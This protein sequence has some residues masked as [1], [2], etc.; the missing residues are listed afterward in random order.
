MT[1][2]ELQTELDKIRPLD[3]E[4][5]AKARAYQDSLAKPPGSLGK[6][7]DIAVQ[8]AG[9][10]GKLASDVSKRRIITL[11]ADNGITEEGVSSAPVTVTMAQAVNMTKRLTG[12]SSLAKAF[13]DDVEV[14]DV[15]IATPYDCPAIIDRK[16]RAGTRN[17]AKE[18]ALTE[19]E[20]LEAIGVGLERA[21]KASSDG[22]GVIGVGE[23]GIGNTTTSAAVLSVLTGLSVEA[24]TGRGGGLT[25]KAFKRKKEVIEDAIR[26]YQ[27]DPSDPINVIAKVGGLDIAAMCGVFLGAAVCRIPVVVDGFISVVAALCA[28][29]LAPLC[30]DF[31]FPSHA[32]YE[33]GY[34]AAADA[35]GLEPYL[36]LGMR[37]GEGSGCPIAFKIIE[38]AE[39]VMANMA[40]FEG[41]SINDNYLEEIRSAESFKVADDP[42]YSIVSSA[43]EA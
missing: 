41:A 28:A 1:R 7:E 5:R 8:L 30:K 38:A 11:C 27:P 15:G 22:I 3:E 31:M 6:L 10:T 29:R 32:S 34:K 17:F 39:A 37:L 12:M 26:A 35:L 42:G 18:P 23:M 19:E 33:I 40:T 13:G 43:Q 20:V 2:Q 21:A 16:I 25:E 14:V 4:A 36:L 9:I 24:V